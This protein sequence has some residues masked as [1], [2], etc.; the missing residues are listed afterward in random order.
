MVHLYGEIP[1]SIK[2]NELSCHV[3]M[4]SVKMASTEQDV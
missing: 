4:L 1:C 2:R 3:D